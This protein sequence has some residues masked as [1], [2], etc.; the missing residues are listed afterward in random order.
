MIEHL[1]EGTGPVVVAVLWVLIACSGSFWRSQEMCMSR[2]L[3][4]PNQFVS[5]TSAMIRSRVTTRPACD[6]SSASRSNS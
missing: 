5:Q 3:V 1:F 4:E 2:V 6:A